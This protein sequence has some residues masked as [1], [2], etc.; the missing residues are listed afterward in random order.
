MIRAE[1][2]KENLH[3]T[4]W[5]SEQVADKLCVSQRIAR[6]YLNGQRKIP[7]R[8][9]S[10]IPLAQFSGDTHLKSRQKKEQRISELKKFSIAVPFKN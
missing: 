4:G 3:N 7:A 6:M 5:N 10:L 1:K 2:A 9:R 8:L